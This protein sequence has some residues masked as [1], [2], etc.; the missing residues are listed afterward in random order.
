MQQFK[1]E[2]N[3][4]KKGKKGPITI[5]PDIVLV[6]VIICFLLAVFHKYTSDEHFV[7]FHIFKYLYLKNI[8]SQ[9]ID[10]NM[11]S[12]ILFNIKQ[13]IEMV[14]LAIEKLSLQI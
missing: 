3:T 9:T 12:K 7:F 5:R 14:I 1:K 11:H 4:K 13:Y 10:H 6:F 8:L 2:K